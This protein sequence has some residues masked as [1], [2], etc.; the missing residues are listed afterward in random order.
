M[1]RMM[2][3][4]APEMRRT[5]NLNIDFRPFEPGTALYLQIAEQII[6]KIRQGRLQP[7]TVMP[8][9]R[10]LAAM[11]NVNRKTIVLSYDE[12]I[13]QGWLTTQHRRGTFVSEA[14]PYPA[15]TK[16][17]EVPEPELAFSSH[18]NSIPPLLPQKYMLLL[19]EGLPDKRVIPYDKYVRAS[20]RAMAKVARASNMD[21]PDYKGQAV[22]R[23]AVASLLH[24]ECGFNVGVENLCLTRGLQ[25]SIY[26]SAR[27][28]ISPGDYVIFERWSPSEAL[29]VFESLGAHILFADIDEAGVK[30]DDVEVLCRHHPVKAIFVTH[31]VQYPTTVSL[32][33]S[34]RKRLLK[35]AEELNFHI[36]ASD[37]SQQLYFNRPAVAPVA[38]G[39]MRKRIIYIGALPSI[40]P[41]DR[42]VGYIANTP[43][44]IDK[45]ARQR[46]LMGQVDDPVSQSAITELIQTGEFHRIA[47]RASRIYNIRRLHTA[48]MLT[49]EL[50]D[51][52]SFRM[53]EAGLFF[54]L[55]LKMD[56]TPQLLADKAEK[57]GIQLVQNIHYAGDS[58]RVP[59][60]LLGYS[61]LDEFQMREL[62]QKIKEM[63]VHFTRN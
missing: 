15:K 12:L 45:C 24:D 61:H 20:K 58:G 59:G 30:D 13:A 22:F 31:Q 2:P 29:S 42:Q 1:P 23:E 43:Q 36:I 25:Q 5:W 48:N 53:P 34:R 41:A 27:A 56:I 10:E 28:L 6:E 32:P 35:L 8:G 46:Q 62:I 55:T 50:D 38:T 33:V 16:L 14:L 60:L 47:R 4:V 44:F 39:N 49:D 21:T 54:W 18:G 52:V 19:S 3:S 11:L 57:A 51:F 40:L 26:I 37:Y 63:R 17:L 7:R 9:S